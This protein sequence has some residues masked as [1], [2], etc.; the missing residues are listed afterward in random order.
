MPQK[1]K[2]LITVKTYPS[3]S[4]SYDEIVRGTK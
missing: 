2:V 3:P 4:K 1:I